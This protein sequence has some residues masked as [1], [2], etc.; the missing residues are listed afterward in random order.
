MIKAALNPIAWQW[1]ALQVHWYGV[2]IATGVVL[3]LVLSIREGKRQGIEEDAFFNGRITGC[4]RVKL[5]PFGTAGSPSMGACSGALPCYGG[6]VAA[7]S[8][9]PGSSWILS[10][11]RLSWPKAWAGGEIS[12]TR[13]PLGE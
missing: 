9:Q 5:L 12:L 3:A 11:R 2:I 4:T 13:K 8:A 10:P 1:G 6:I 7:S